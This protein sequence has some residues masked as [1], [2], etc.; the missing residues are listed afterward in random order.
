M[1]KMR[2]VIMISGNGSNMVALIQATRNQDFPAEIVAVI[3]DK[4]QA[5]GIAKARALGVETFV[6]ERK[7]FTD[8][9]AHEAA[10]LEILARLDPDLICLAGYMRLMSEEMVMR[11]QG[12]MLNIHPSL[13]P[14][15][16]GLDTHRRALEAG[17]KIAGCTV[18][19][20]TPVMDSGP[21]LA[22]AAVPVL[23][24]DDEARLKAR[25]LAAEH[26]LY[27]QALRQFIHN[28][29]ARAASSLQADFE[30]AGDRGTALFS[31]GQDATTDWR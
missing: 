14:L 28:R 8:Q 12:R 21:I 16:P 17:V 31:Y 18:H 11:Y 13:L 9:A 22:Q 1:R 2:I 4:A 15:F 5:G 6:C 29:S 27:A 24:G 26:R 10:M 25:V 23:D 19:I 20:V 30:G 7:N 3:C